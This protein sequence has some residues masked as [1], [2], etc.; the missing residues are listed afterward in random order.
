MAGGA[1][2]EMPRRHAPDAVLAALARSLQ[3]SR[4]PKVK[5]AVLEYFSAAAT[6]LVD[7]EDQ[8][9]LTA[10]SALR[11][12]L[13]AV[14]QLVLDKNPDIRRAAARAVSVVYLAE[15]GPVVVAA[16]QGLP[17]AQVLAVQRA[18][19][20]AAPSLEADLAAAARASRP[21]AV[22]G[23]GVG[24]APTTSSRR[25][26]GGGSRRL[27]ELSLAL[28][29]AR[30]TTA[31]ASSKPCGVGA[32][33][34]GSPQGVSPS[35]RLSSGDGS[36]AAAS[37]SMSRLGRQASSL[38]CGSMAAAEPTDQLLARQPSSCV[39]HTSSPT[40]VQPASRTASLS[41]SAAG[42][43]A[44]GSPQPP[45][46]LGHEASYS[47]PLGTSGPSTMAAQQ[48]AVVERGQ[49][50]AGQRSHEA[51]QQPARSAAG[52]MLDLVPFDGIMEGQLRRLLA[53]LQGRPSPEVF[54]GLSRLAHVLPG[55]TWT[56]HFSQ[57]CLGVGASREGC[58]TR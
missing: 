13:A 52:S 42:Q 48:E 43:A 9:E 37:P 45:S 46:P 57:V 35:R 5:V 19:A 58:S 18:L 25:H 31:S 21:A 14:L 39:T 8:L 36:P 27:P 44:A 29:S 47:L 56:S 22:A 23:A 33:V 11:A 17:P 4:A 28:L 50:A 26:S 20:P 53:K 2:A 38:P 24:A 16:L 15:Q 55:S 51:Q 30:G 7:L 12:L 1:L 41:M 34:L 54:Q 3:Q 40:I 32:G 49:A 6:G 10:G